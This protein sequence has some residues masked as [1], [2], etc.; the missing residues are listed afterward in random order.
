M[1][2]LHRVNKK[3]LTT[4]KPIKHLYAI[5]HLHISFPPDMLLLLL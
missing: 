1:Y 2:A 4:L 5:S 3:A